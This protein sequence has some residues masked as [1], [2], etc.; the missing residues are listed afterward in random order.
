MTNEIVAFAQARAKAAVRRVAVPAAFALVGGVFV[1]FALVGLFAALFFW[2]ELELWADRRL[3][4]LRGGRDRSRDA[5][6]A[7]AR[8]VQAPSSAAAAGLGGTL[9]QFVSLLAQRAPRLAPRQLV[10]TAALVGRRAGSLRA[11][12]EE[13]IC[14]NRDRYS[15]GRRATAPIAR[16]G[17][18]RR[19]AA[20]STK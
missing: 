12:G 1:L 6:A 10:V 14:R 20:Y 13:I 5:G 18:G 4:D 19:G 11:R 15:P 2:L 7:A 9:P 16:P 8:H 17:R 3:A